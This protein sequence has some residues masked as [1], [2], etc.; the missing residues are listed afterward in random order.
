MMEQSIQRVLDAERK[1]ELM[2]QKAEEEK[3]KRLTDARHK[4]LQE[5]SRQENLINA[6]QEQ[7]IRKKKGELEKQRKDTIAKGEASIRKA[8][9]KSR[10]VMDKAV[11]FILDQFDQAIIGKEHHTER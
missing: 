4:A 5:L 1:A 2:L 3:A 11:Q 6:E 8:E 7:L 9:E 10:A